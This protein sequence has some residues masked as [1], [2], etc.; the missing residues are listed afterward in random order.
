MKPPPKKKFVL[1]SVFRIQKQVKICVR[2][3]AACCGLLRPAAACWLK[4]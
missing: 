1:K 3:A 4:L 2:P